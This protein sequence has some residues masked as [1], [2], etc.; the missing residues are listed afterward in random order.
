[1]LDDEAYK[2]YF[3]IISSVSEVKM[4]HRGIERLS[5][6]S[7]RSLSCLFQF[8]HVN[9]LHAHHDMHHFPNFFSTPYALHPGLRKDLP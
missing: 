1:M 2:S 9:F 6:V 7:L 3:V 5:L 4:L 8:L